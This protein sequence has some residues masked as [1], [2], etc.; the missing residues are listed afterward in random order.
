MTSSYCPSLSAEVVDGAN[1]NTPTGSDVTTRVMR[2]G[3]RLLM[4]RCG[5][6]FLPVGMHPAFRPQRQCAVNR[7]TM[8]T[9]VTPSQ[10]V[11]KMDKAA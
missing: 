9:I 1:K 3:T 8:S 10:D 11:T 5:S 6:V 2:D 7:M 4:A